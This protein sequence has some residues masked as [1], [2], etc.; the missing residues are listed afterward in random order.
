MNGAELSSSAGS[1]DT[2]T[3]RVT[4][5]T[6]LTNGVELTL[7]GTLYDSEGNSRLH[8][9]EFAA[10]NNGVAQ[11][12]DGGW[13]RNAFASLSWKGLSLEG[14]FTRRRKTWPTAPYSTPDAIAIFNDPR[15]ISIDG[16][17]LRASVSNTRQRTNGMSRSAPTTT[18]TSL[19]ACIPSTTSTRSSRSI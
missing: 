7:S 2:Y 8:Y 18:I 12:M 9:P 15:F 5:G 13:A 14:G 1:F 17:H 11:D 3:G 6:M 16:A 10:I 19:M 4:Y